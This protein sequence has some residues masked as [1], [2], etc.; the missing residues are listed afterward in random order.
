[1]E[2]DAEAAEGAGC[3]ARGSGMQQGGE[4]EADA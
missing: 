3:E 2:E 1:M 4:L